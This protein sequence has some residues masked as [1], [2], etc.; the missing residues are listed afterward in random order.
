MNR[1]FI[2][3]IISV[4]VFGCDTASKTQKLADRGTSVEIPTQ[5]NSIQAV[6]WQQHSAEYRALCEQAYNFARLS[7]DAILDTST[8]DVS[9]LAI[10]TDLD[11]TVIDNSPMNAKM[12]ELDEPY[13]RSRWIE[14]GDRVSAEAMPGAVEFFK[15]AASRGV[16]TYY[17]SNR[18]GEQLDVTIENLRKLDLPFV[19]K[20]HVMLRDETSGSGK[21]S[22]RDV[23]EETHSI[24]MLLGDNLSDFSEKF[25]NQRS[26]RRH[27]LVDSLRKE[28]GSRFIIL[29]NV[30]YGDWQTN[31]IYEGRYDWTEFQ[32]DSIRRAKL[33][34]Y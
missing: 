1:I 22:R 18:Y 17:I 32:K 13:Q 7:L 25:E 28:F 30:I 34:S 21:K 2:V 14:W 27:E 5:E 29:P 19:D 3:V 15:Y 20:D 9:S 4:M 11:E 16:V 24:I 26:E 23:V 12:I 31:G 8:A 6:L 10:V 33:I